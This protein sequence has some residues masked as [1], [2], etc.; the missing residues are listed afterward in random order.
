M[1]RLETFS[2]A[3]IE[4]LKNQ[5]SPHLEEVRRSRNDYEDKKIQA[6]QH[7]L[8]YLSIVVDG[9]D[10]T[11]YRLPYMKSYKSKLS[12]KLPQLNVIG[13]KVHGV[14]DLIFTSFKNFR[15]DSNLNI[16][17]IQRTLEYYEKIKSK[18]IQR[19]SRSSPSFS[20][21]TNSNQEINPPRSNSSQTENS[22]WKFPP[23]L[24]VQL[25]NTCK[26]NKNIYVLGYF[27]LWTT[28]LLRAPSG[29]EL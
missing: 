4:Y 26:E 18:P 8:G 11:H 10:Q 2:E 24:Y 1:A 14:C 23:T 28:P 21:S 29:R 19:S 15:H 6:I 7:P 20:S 9:A 27:S 3:E 5:L 22:N 17:C 12:E 25:D 13:V 16:E